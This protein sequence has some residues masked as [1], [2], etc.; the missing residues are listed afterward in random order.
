M[1]ISFSIL[2]LAAAVSLD[3]FSVGLS[4]GLKNMKVPVKSIVIIALCSA[5]SLLIAMILGEMIQPLLPPYIANRIGGIIF[6]LIGGWALFQFFRQ[7]GP[8]DAD[9]DRSGTITGL[10]AVVLGFALSLDSFG[11]GIAAAIIGYPPVT[12][13][14]FIAVMS[15]L[16]LTAGLNI[17]RIF[18]HLGWV[19]RVSFLPG[20]LLVLIGILK[21]R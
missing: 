1:N 17:G 19:K 14:V 20:V 21:I 12:L 4:Y 10:E 3:S 16:F 7:K 2:L 8:I 13:A 5:F 18:S 15:F 11:A 9:F 6:I